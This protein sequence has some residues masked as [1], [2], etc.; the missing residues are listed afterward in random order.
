[1]VFAKMLLQHLCVCKSQEYDG[2]CNNC[3]DVVNSIP[4]KRKMY[5]FLRLDIQCND[6]KYECIFS[7]FKKCDKSQQKALLKIQGCLSN[8]DISMFMF[9]DNTDQK[10]GEKFQV[11]R[12]NDV[13]FNSSFEGCEEFIKSNLVHSFVTK[14][15][16]NK[17]TEGITQLLEGEA[18]CVI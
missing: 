11:R 6:R 4:S 8:T 13:P 10:A 3:I 16:S 18:V 9:M 17:F 15:Q 1:M 12:I 7:L 2:S 5:D 14:H